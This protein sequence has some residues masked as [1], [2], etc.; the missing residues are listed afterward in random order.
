M[1]LLFQCM[2]CKDKQLIM[3]YQHTFI[4]GFH[5]FGQAFTLVYKLPIEKTEAKSCSAAT[6]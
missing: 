3:N 5:T 4:L 2:L 6:W 1:E